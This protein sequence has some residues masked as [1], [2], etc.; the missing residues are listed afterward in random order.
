MSN[1]YEKSTEFLTRA[2]A[3]IPIG[4]QTFS[5]SRTQYPVGISPLF[6]T[7]AKGPYLWDLDGN[8]YIDLVSNL[9]SITLGYRNQKVDSAVRKQMNL[10][11]GFSLPSTLEAVVAE[12]ITSLVP[13]AEMV[14]FGKNGTDATSAAIRLARAYTGRDYV[15]VCGYHG[16]Q[17]WFIG[18]TSRNK[19]VPKKTS[20]L[21][22]TFKYNDIKSLEKIFSKH[23]KG[24]AAVILEP[25]TNEFPENKFLEKTKKL[26]RK[27][28]AVLIFD[29]TITGFR[30]SKGGAQE[31]FQVTPDLSTFGKGIANG[32]PLS[33][34]CGSREIMREM[35]N[36][37][38]S[39]TFGGELLSLAAA[40]VVLGMHQKDE[41]SPRLN[42]YGEELSQDLQKV[43]DQSDM[44][45]LLEIK[46][47]P[48][49]KFLEWKDGSE[50]TAP[51]LK[52]FFMQEMFRS[53]ILILSTHNVTLAH[54]KKIRGVIISKYERVL[55]LMKKAI[56]SGNL[57]D[58]L[59]V[60]PLKPL[61]KVR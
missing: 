3:T 60:V 39:G 38:F 20:A 56:N 47:H 37:F 10:G 4:S 54:N 32:Y 43:I 19:G 30:F 59:E 55:T 41:I 49:W 18:S 1:R 23:P 35:E 22:L 5:K 29:E 12:K 61:F 8:K 42:K 44:S 14:R 34:V 25:M 9:A 33:V 26:C 52:T 28:G 17:D 45:G 6:A 24:I 21:T 58:K 2:E 53:G 7:R 46:G 15:A 48:T 51:E 36:I 16:W 50:S 13:S 11:N 27:Y 31:V 40:N 57:K